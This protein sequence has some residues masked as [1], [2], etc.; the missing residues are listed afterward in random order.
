MLTRGHSRL[1]PR[2]SEPW[3]QRGSAQTTSVCTAC[4]VTLRVGSFCQL[5]STCR[6]PA[7]HVP[8]LPGGQ[9]HLLPLPPLTLKHLWGRVFIKSDPGRPKLLP[10][11]PG[12]GSCVTLAP[13]PGADPPS[14]KRLGPAPYS[15]PRENKSFSAHAGKDNAPRDAG[16]S[17]HQ[18]RAGPRLQAEG[19]RRPLL[20]LATG[21]H[22]RTQFFPTLGPQQET[23]AGGSPQEPGNRLHPYRPTTPTN[24]VKLLL[25]GPAL[26]Y[27]GNLGLQVPVNR[28]VPKIRRAN[29]RETGQAAPCQVQP[30]ACR[31]KEMCR[32]K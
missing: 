13:T 15:H 21:T 3:P 18:A 9:P 20:G 24:L 8:L 10:N 22:K 1:G 19:C 14:Q 12:R 6:D 2:Q 31:E 23:V 25:Q 5:V 27:D 7:S 4:E 16:E 11:R 26:R 28:P 32:Q 30:E 17:A 29:Q